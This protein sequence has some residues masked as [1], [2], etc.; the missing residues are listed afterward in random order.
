MSVSHRN[1]EHTD[2]WA[3][4]LV[5]GIIAALYF[6]RENSGPSRLRFNFD[7]SFDAGS[8]IAGEA[9]NRSRSFR[10][11][12]RPCIDGRGWLRRLGN[13]ESTG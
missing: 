7:V 4:V 12:H 2:T 13:S 1:A 5:A 10:H 3:V 6:T 9:T 8:Y 11:S